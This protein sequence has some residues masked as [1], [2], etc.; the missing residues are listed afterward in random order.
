MLRPDPAFEFLADPNGGLPRFDPEQQWKGVET[1]VFLE[2][3]DAL[4]P[5]FGP[6]LLDV[7][8]SQMTA[9]V[10]PPLGGQ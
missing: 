3:V 10:E 2:E 8:V 7:T 6:Q 5:R 1:A 4:T 9:C